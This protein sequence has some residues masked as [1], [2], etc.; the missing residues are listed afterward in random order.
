MFSPAAATSARLLSDF[1]AALKII[2]TPRPP[3]PRVR[4]DRVMFCN[5]IHAMKCGFAGRL[6][7]V[8]LVGFS[9]CQSGYGATFLD[10]VY[11]ALSR[12]SPPVV[13]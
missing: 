2:D 4:L 5:R 12:M 8:H 3:P 11:D 1:D 9:S 7:Y 6:N 13:N 10:A